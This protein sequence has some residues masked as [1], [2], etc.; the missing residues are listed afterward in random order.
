TYTYHIILIALFAEESGDSL[1]RAHASH[2]DLSQHLITRVDT[3]ITY[4]ILKYESILA[5]HIVLFWIRESGDSIIRI[6]KNKGEIQLR[7]KLQ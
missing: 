5:D 1:I 4:C 3:F 7:M 6:I 2:L